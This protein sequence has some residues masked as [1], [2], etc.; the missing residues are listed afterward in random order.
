MEQNTKNQLRLQEILFE[1]LEEVHAAHGGT[2]AFNY[3]M[4]KAEHEAKVAKQ[5]I[6]SAD[7]HHRLLPR[8]HSHY[9]QKMF[10]DTMMNQT[11]APH[12]DK[13]QEMEFS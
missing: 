4:T 12:A 13:T 2:A 5:I 6:N 3:T 8:Y 9:L 1:M 11:H 10:A 7:S